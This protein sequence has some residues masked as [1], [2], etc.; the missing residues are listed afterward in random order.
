MM[1]MMR[2]MMLIIIIIIILRL[3]SS[4]RNW[5][6]QPTAGLNSSVHRQR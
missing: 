6:Y 4:L 5:A 3:E 1:V 2:M